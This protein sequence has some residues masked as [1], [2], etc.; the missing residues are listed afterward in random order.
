MFKTCFN[1]VSVITQRIRP[2]DLPNVSDMKRNME[3]SRGSS[4]NIATELRVGQL[5]F[6]T[7][8]GRNFYSLCYV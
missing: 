7:R 8:E 3:G 5:G 4:V 2:L 1:T 6:D